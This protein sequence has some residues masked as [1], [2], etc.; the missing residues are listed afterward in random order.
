MVGKRLFG[1]IPAR[2]GA[3]FPSRRRSPRS[4]ARQGR[5]GSDRRYCPASS[6]PP[7]P[8]S[9]T[10]KAEGWRLRRGSYLA[11]DSDTVVG[12]CAYKFQPDTAGAVEIAYSTFPAY[13][14]RG[15]AKGMISALFAMA[16]RSGASM[17]FAHTLPENNASNGALR[18]EGFSSAGEVTDPDDGL[19]WR[20]EKRA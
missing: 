17:V 18:R 6:E 19:V 11:W 14:G 9:A 8:R 15:F 3:R 16:V 5:V 7:A 20:W 4:R 1:L 10:G 2:S 13:E 12:V